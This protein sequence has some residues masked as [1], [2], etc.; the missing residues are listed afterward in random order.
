MYIL[1]IYAYA[2]IHG[3]AYIHTHICI[4][5]YTYT[6]IQDRTR[7]REDY[8]YE[9]LGDGMLLRNGYGARNV[10]V[11]GI[12]RRYVSGA[13]D[14]SDHRSSGGE[15]VRHSRKHGAGTKWA[16]MAYRCVCV[17]HVCMCVCMFVC[18]HTQAWCW[19]KVGRDG[20]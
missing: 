3:Y 2:Y 9:G 8:E 12:Y 10:D 5:I 18:V 4:Y 20:V 19:N 6:Y 16:E 1:Y 15:S 13:G 14:G 17:V 11:D 7:D